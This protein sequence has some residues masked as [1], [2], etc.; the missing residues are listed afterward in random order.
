MIRH[1]VSI[2][3]VF[4]AISAAAA[5]RQPPQALDIYLTP[6]TLATLPDG[7][8]IH[9]FCEGEGGPTTILD[10]GWGGWST[11]WRALSTNPMS[12]LRRFRT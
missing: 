3:L 11:A 8:H 7:R 12:L 1:F 10:A 5:E 4:C 6:Q 9:F 2:A